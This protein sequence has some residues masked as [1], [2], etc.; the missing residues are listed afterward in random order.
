MTNDGFRRM[1]WSGTLP[2][3]A[4]APGSLPSAPAD[5]GSRELQEALAVAFPGGV[6][7]EVEVLLRP[8]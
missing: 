2:P 8:R 6:P 7:A 1:S 4:A 5:T 3:P